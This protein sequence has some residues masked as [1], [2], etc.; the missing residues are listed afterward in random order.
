MNIYT[1]ASIREKA[2]LDVAEKMMIAARTAPKARG[3]DNLEI[4]MVKK[5][6]IKEISDKMKEMFHN[7]R[8]PEFFVRDANNILHADAIVLIGTKIR[9]VKVSNCGL[10]GFVDCE[11]KKKHEK[12]PCIFNTGDLGI[13]VGSAVSVAMDARVD[14][15]IMYSIGKA[16]KELNI[17]DASVEIIYVIPLSSSGKNVFFDRK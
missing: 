1:E 16:V 8:A 12:H 7:N 6:S 4:A 2:L 9:P 3:F 10:C 13:A 11:E 17:F 5:D 14:N 15:R